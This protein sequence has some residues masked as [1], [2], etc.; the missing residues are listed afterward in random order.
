[1]VELLLLLCGLCGQGEKAHPRGGNKTLNGLKGPFKI[2][3]NGF[4][5]PLDPFAVHLSRIVVAR[6]QMA[7]AQRVRQEGA[8]LMTLPE[9]AVHGLSGAGG[10]VSIT[11][12][13]FTQRMLSMLHSIGQGGGHGERGRHVLGHGGHG[14]MGGMGGMGGSSAVTAAA[15]AAAAAGASK[16]DEDGPVVCVFPLL[17]RLGRFDTAL[18]CLARERGA[19]LPL[20]LSRSIVAVVRSA[21]KRSRYELMGFNI[22]TGETEIPHCTFSLFASFIFF[23]HT[24][25]HCIT[26]CKITLC[27]HT[28]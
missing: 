20:D 1:M 9:A 4:K 5:G 28:L 18:R 26:L 6:L 23:V 13:A 19:R 3:L 17:T 16:S 14:G 10:S 15:A 21:Y 2:P 25:S 22:E 7:V 8:S 12:G 11:L 24:V 27:I